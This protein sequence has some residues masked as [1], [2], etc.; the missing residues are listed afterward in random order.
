ML[1]AVNKSLCSMA[2]VN[3]AL[4]NTLKLRFELGLFDPIEDQPLWHVPLSQVNTSD[5]RANSMLATLESMVLLANA[6]NTLPLA[7]GQHVAVIGPH[8][9]SQSAMA[10]NYLGLSRW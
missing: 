9:Q 4:Y 6:N 8:A 5:S 3:R 2:D 1:S 10:G 7:K